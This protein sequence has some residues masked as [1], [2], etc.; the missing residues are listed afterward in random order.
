VSFIVL[1]LTEV[2]EKEIVLRKILAGQIAA[3]VRLT[4]ALSGLNLIPIPSPKRRREE[5]I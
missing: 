4:P 1:G 5:L 2:K 3:L